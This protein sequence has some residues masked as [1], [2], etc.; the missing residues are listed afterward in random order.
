MLIRY[1][2]LIDHKLVLMISILLASIFE[3]AGISLVYPIIYLIFDE[4]YSTQ[5]DNIYFQKVLNLF[6]Y[7]INFLIFI[8]IILISS[9]FI[10]LFIYNSINM[11]VS[12]KFLNNLRKIF[13]K[14]LFES[15]Y[16]HNYGNSSLILNILTSQSKN[17]QSSLS[18][19]FRILQI[20]LM[21][22][23]LFILGLII[24]YKLF[25][26]SILF[27]IFVFIIFKS[28]VNKSKL[29]S[30]KLIS[31][32]EDYL[33]LVNQS[34]SNYKFI[35]ITNTFNYLL[36]KIISKLE[37]IR[38]ENLKY[39]YLKNLTSL[40]NEPILIII[41]VS[42]FYIGI[43]F[44][45]LNFPILITLL[46]ILYRFNSQ[47]FPIFSYYQ[48]FKFDFQS[49]VY[50]NSRIDSLSQNQENINSNL[51]INEIKNLEI[52][53]A[54]FGYN[55]TLFQIKYLKLERGTITTI[56]GI[57]GS[58]K[59]TLIDSILNLI[60]IR[61]GSILYNQKNLND[62]N[63][64]KLRSKI[65]Y[66][67]QDNSLFNETIYENINLRKSN[68]DNNIIYE[69]IEELELEQ[70]FENNQID[71]SFMI[72]ESKDNLS[73]GEKQRIAFIREI[74]HNPD[75]LIID[76]AFNSLDKNS[77]SKVEALIKKIKKNMII[78]NIAH[79]DEL[80]NISNKIYEIRNN[81]LV[82]SK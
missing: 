6:D 12:H 28:I 36:S 29:I 75:I 41:L 51:I 30:K 4:N 39:L 61:S 5:I 74:S 14:K 23:F 47:I 54:S 72:N 82:L 40:S 7:N 53:D 46:V 73:G 76:E 45:N 16:D 15:R 56:K 1:L 13:F 67:G 37:G 2:S 77:Y 25:L 31:L 38:K 81:L 66:L 70:I 9:K 10:F 24:S 34:N 55:K 17:A 64:K 60:D 27:E 69:Y 62:I 42:I 63:F 32:E 26:L 18:L 22:F 33:N 8:I 80:K 79:H 68:I 19:I 43:N 44:F 50:I 65:G 52:I 35:K 78:I 20:T 49:F 11:N 57:S 21:S 71:L 59:T 3:L 58:G 48:R